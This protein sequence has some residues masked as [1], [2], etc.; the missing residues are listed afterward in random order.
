MLKH[1]DLVKEGLMGLDLL[2]SGFNCGVISSTSEGLED[3]GVKQ[4]EKSGSV[5][6]DSGVGD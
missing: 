5:G 2:L 4:S 6:V 3:R 1:F